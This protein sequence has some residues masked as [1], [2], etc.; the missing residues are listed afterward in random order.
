V[1]VLESLVAMSKMGFH[2]LQIVAHMMCIALLYL[3]DGGSPPP[4]PP[5]D[6]RRRGEGGINAIV[7]M[8]NGAS[9]ATITMTR[10]SSWQEIWW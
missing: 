9:I 5:L 10:C 7:S 4:S 1:M 2:H 3:D 6:A 8:I